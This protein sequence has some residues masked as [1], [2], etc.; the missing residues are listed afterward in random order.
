LLSLLPIR[1]RDRMVK[2]ALGL[3]GTL[4]PAG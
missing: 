4:N 3:S 2:S 1:L